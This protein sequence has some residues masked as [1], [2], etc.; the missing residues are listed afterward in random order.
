M[1]ARRPVLNG[2]TLGAR[3]LA[4]S[5]A[6]YDRLL[7]PLALERRDAG[8][9]EIGYGGPGELPAIWV[10]LPYDGRPAT[11]GNGTH[12]AF[13]AP[14]NAAVDAFYA[15]GLAAGGLDEGAPGLRPHYAADYYGAYLRD[16][17]GNKLQAVHYAEVE[18]AEIVE[19]G[20]FSHVTLGTGDIARAQRFYDATLAPLGLVR[21]ADEADA[22]GKT[23]ASAWGLPG[24]RL[25]WFYAHRP[26][27][28][29]PPSWANGTQIDFRAP[30]RGAVEAFH[31]A[32]LAAGGLDE[33]APGPRDYRP[34]YY[35]AYLRDP[36]GNKLHAFCEPQG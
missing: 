17:V 14:S 25:G 19:A 22:D 12:L 27:D 32:G 35:G 16:P 2:A 31:A 15:A 24:S 36:D 18:P 28:G 23:E 3:D 29:R 13:L 34:G 26:F 10:L 7:A 9:R 1:I 11:W 8:A 33:G 20:V 5:G 6:F 30:D 21:V 4:A